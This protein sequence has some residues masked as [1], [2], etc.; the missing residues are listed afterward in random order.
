MER[1]KFR[2]WLLG[3]DLN[4]KVISDHLSRVARIERAFSISLNA[5]FKKDQFSRLFS[6]FR[7]YGIN[8]DVQKF[9]RIDL[10]VGKTSMASIKHSLKVYGQ[11]LIE[12]GVE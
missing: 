4:A 10:P 9:S 8:P 2:D 11:F 12:T 3:K 7:R 1:E 6:L 5:E